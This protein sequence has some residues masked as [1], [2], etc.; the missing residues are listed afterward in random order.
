MLA[1]GAF[2]GKGHVRGVSEIAVA[3]V[4]YKALKGSDP[5][6]ASMKW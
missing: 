5:S 3:T 6:A 4:L 1:E 2:L